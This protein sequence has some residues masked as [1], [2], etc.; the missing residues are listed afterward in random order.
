MTQR[1]HRI[2]RLAALD[3]EIPVAAARPLKIT[4][5]DRDALAGFNAQREAAVARARQE[6]ERIAT[7]LARKAIEAVNARQA[8][9]LSRLAERLG[10]AA[11][12]I[13]TKYR[14]NLDTLTLEPLT[15]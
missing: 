5:D 8:A 1:T 10:I 6:A 2:N 12:E 14:I 9:Y 11:D 4:E 3:S 7:D 15:P 13:A